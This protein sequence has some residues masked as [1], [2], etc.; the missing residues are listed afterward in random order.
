MLP[1]VT[2][3]NAKRP[4]IYVQHDFGT[5]RTPISCLV[6]TW[7]LVLFNTYFNTVFVA[8][9]IGCIGRKFSGTIRPSG[10]QL[11]VLKLIPAISWFV[12]RIK[13]EK[14]VVNCRFASGF[15]KFCGS[16]SP[17][18]HIARFARVAVFA[19]ADA[20]RIVKTCCRISGRVRFEPCPRTACFCQASISKNGHKWTID[21]CGS[22]IHGASHSRSVGCFF[23]YPTRRIVVLRHPIGPIA[24]DDFEKHPTISRLHR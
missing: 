15:I 12:L 16:P 23:G 9:N 10:A 4:P 21:S 17:F 8:V 24:G 20:S 2:C 11:V 22:G 7:Y 1:C 18:V 5:V 3:R 6:K 19:A 14:T 13:V